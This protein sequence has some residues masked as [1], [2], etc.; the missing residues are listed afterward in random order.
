MRAR[1][2]RQ[3]LQVGNGRQLVDQQPHLHPAP[4]RGQQLVQH[5]SCAVVLVENV[6][7]QV[8]AGL[9]TADQVDARKQRIL[10]VIQDQGVMAR[11]FAR[12][13]GLGALAQVVQRRLQHTGIVLRAI[14]DFRTRGFGDRSGPLALR[15]GKPGAGA[16]QQDQ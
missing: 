3:D 1:Q 11:C 10:A 4:R 15:I 9:C 6:G 13:F 2:G 7:L 16:A 14:D 8:D 5:Q 12:G